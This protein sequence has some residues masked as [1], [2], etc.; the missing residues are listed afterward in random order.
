MSFRAFAQLVTTFIFLSVC[1]MLNRATLE[2]QQEKMRTLALI[3]PTKIL[4]DNLTKLAPP[5]I[6][7]GVILLTFIGVR[8]YF[9]CVVYQVKSTIENPLINISINN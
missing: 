3:N 9:W 1:H 5:V 8:Y 2:I 6:I 7:Y 4:M